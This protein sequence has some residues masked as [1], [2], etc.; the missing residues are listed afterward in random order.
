MKQKILEDVLDEDS[1]SIDAVLRLLTRM[2]EE[3]RSG[4]TA[5]WENPTLERYLEALHAWLAAVS[6]RVDKKLSWKLV[7]VMLE[8]AKIYE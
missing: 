5:D 7:E 1:G 2:S 4:N 3:L 8:A 6:K